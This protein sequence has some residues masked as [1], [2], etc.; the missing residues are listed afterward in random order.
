MESTVLEKF[1]IVRIGGG[2][3]IFPRYNGELNRK[4]HLPVSS[5]LPWVFV[6][7]E[8]CLG[9]PCLGAEGNAVENVLSLLRGAPSHCLANWKENEPCFQEKA[10]VMYLCSLPIWSFLEKGPL[11]PRPTGKSTILPTSV[12]VRQ[13]QLEKKSF[14]QHKHFLHLFRWE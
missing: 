3:S 1:L 13:P 10:S 4:F 9:V 11:V 7:P 14:R 2:N 8:A 6:V 12:N 5:P